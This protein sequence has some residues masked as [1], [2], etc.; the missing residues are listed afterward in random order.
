MPDSLSIPSPHVAKLRAI[1]SRIEERYGDCATELRLLAVE[2][3]RL[4]RQNR[5]LIATKPSATVLPF[6][7]PSGGIRTPRPITP[8]TSNKDEP[9]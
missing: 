3:A 7:L 8:D 5:E 1:A 6:R 4:E 2:M 9:T